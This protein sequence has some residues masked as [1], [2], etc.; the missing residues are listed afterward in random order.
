MC[1]RLENELGITKLHVVTDLATFK[2]L[3][4]CVF[5]RYQGVNQCPCCHRPK[6]G[7][8]TGNCLINTRI[9]ELEKFLETK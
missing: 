5:N 9:A 1:D 4:W 3:E 2:K 7:G 6:P 8:H